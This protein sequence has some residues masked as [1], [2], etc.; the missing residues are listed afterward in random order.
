MA[1]LKQ[2]MVFRQE[3]LLTSIQQTLIIQA[4]HVWCRSYPDFPMA[5]VQSKGLHDVVRAGSSPSPRSKPPIGC[6]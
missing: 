3:A 4:I 6:Q 1:V 5:N 2:S